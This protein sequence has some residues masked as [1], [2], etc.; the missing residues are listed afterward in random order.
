M[1]P[2]SGLDPNSFAS[3]TQPMVHWRVV[4]LHLAA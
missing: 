4:A 1:K 2:V 3:E